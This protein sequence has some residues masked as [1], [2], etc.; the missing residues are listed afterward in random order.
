MLPKTSSNKV[1]YDRKLPW[2]QNTPNP[3]SDIHS[4]FCIISHC[5]RNGKCF[6]W[7]LLSSHKF[8]EEIKI[9]SC[10]DK[11]ARQ[12]YESMSHFWKKCLFWYSISTRMISFMVPKVPLALLIWVPSMQKKVEL[13]Q[14]VLQLC[15]IGDPNTDDLVKQR[16]EY[17]QHFFYFQN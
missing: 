15:C 2:N 6:C 16:K 1:I 14:K 11:V 3:I 10:R 12:W 17:M 13:F 9:P 4:H 8:L 5:S 7:P